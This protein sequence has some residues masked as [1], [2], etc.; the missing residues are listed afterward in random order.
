M[1]H[2]VQ[3]ALTVLMEHREQL[4]HQ[5]LPLILQMSAIRVIQ[6]LDILTCHLARQHNDLPHQEQG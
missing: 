5:A 1:E 6:V 2:K 3:L 4:E